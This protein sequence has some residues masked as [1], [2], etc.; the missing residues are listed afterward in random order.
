M[1]Q[2]LASP[3]G[4]SSDVCGKHTRLYSI[5]SRSQGYQLLIVQVETP[6][7]PDDAEFASVLGGIGVPA[8]WHSP[9]STFMTSPED[10]NLGQ[11]W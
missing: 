10:S 7:A 5:R 4:Q 11:K 6:N 8:G 3:V 2:E 9:E 1:K